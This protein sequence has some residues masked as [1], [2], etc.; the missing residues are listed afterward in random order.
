MSREE[1]T[2]IMKV[3]LIIIHYTCTSYSISKITY[4]RPNNLHVG[5]N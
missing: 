4:S 2:L 1:T 5:T 3:I